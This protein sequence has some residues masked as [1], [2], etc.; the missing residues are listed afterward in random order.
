MFI[1]NAM[2]IINNNLSCDYPCIDV[3]H[4]M[5]YP[6]VE[7]NPDFIRLVMVSEAPSPD[8]SNY[9]YKDI[10]APFFQTTMSAFQDAGIM[11]KTYADLTSMG[12]YLTTAIKCPKKDYLVSSVTLKNC[13]EILQKELSQFPDLRAILCMGDFAIKAIN[14]MYKRNTGIAPIK[15]GSTYKIRK[16][17]FELNGIRFFP[18]YTQTGDSFNIEKSKRQ[19]IAEDIK[20]ALS[21]IKTSDE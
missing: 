5:I 4:D 11:L 19:M 3:N 6:Q 13:A 2:R 7:M 8:H 20:N 14:Q 21:Y 17:I 16:E 12:I 10:S 1:Y 18:S 9:F 15:S